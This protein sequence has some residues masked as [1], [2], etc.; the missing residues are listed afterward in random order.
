MVHVADRMLMVSWGRVVTG[1]EERAIEVFNEAVGLYG[2]MQQDGR[3]E[4]FDVA[5]MSP[6]ATLDGYIAL[7]GDAAQLAKVRE[8]P[9]FIRSTADAMLIVNDFA[10]CDGYCNQGVA[11]Q[12]AIFQEA[13]GKVPQ[14]A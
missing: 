4:S 2:T 3:I 6:N 9:D 13:S 12:M 10:I 11:D 14:S 7:K 1:R 8:D 5:L